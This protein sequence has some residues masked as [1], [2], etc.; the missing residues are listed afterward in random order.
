LRLLISGLPQAETLLDDARH[1]GTAIARIWNQ[2][3]PGNTLNN[4]LRGGSVAHWCGCLPQ[5]P[6]VPDL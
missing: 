4:V 3:Q 1:W 6:D 2:D 5:V